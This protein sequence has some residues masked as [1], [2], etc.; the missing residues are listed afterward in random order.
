MTSTPPSSRNS[1]DRRPPRGAAANVTEPSVTA[2]ELRRDRVRS[3]DEYPFHIPEVGASTVSNSRL[4]DADAR[5]D[6]PGL[7]FVIATHSPI[8]IAKPEATICLF[9]ERGLRTV[10]Y[11]DTEHYKITKAFLTRRE[12]M[13]DELLK[14]R[15]DQPPAAPTDH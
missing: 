9:S 4:P 15:S 11:A 7:Q 2:L 1:E 3:F 8:I 10:E 14:P 5:P 13:L 6:R 12:A